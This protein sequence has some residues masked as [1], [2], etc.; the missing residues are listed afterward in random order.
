MN[1][2]KVQGQTLFQWQKD[3]FDLYFQHPKNS[4]FV[5]KSGR[6]R[7][8]THTLQ[9][10]IMYE[11]INK[12]KHHII[13]LT[14]TYSLCRKF[15]KDLTDLLLPIPKLIKNANSSVLEIELYNNAMITLKS[16]ESKNNLRGLNCHTLLIDEGAFINLDTALEC[17][18]FVNVSQGNIIIASTPLT[19]DEENNLFAK[20]WFMAQRGEKNVYSIDFCSY[21]TSALLTP[22]RKEMYRKQLP[23]NI[24]QNEIEGNFLEL[25]NNLWNIQPILRNDVPKTDWFVGGI[26]WATNEKQDETSFSIFN[27]DKQMYQLY[28][29]NDKSPTE[30]IDFIVNIL[31][32]FPIKKLVIEKNSIGSIYLDLLK[33][34]VSQNNIRTN[35]IPF[36]TTNES[37][38]KII[39]SMQLEI[40]NQTTSFL[41]D[42]ELILQ[43]SS[44]EMQTTKSGLI[45]YN[46][47]N[48]YHDDII[49]SNA[50]ALSA[51]SQGSYNIR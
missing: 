11:C 19:K 37:K 32:Q 50:L 42:N 8:K 17:F 6:Q 18:N 46:G 3:F 35:I 39:E 47:A 4:I 20:Y 30:T 45:T 2:N 43:Y 10:L 31:K 16:A 40:M 25:S 1:K 5:I 23:Y 51:F 9:N 15:F 44:Y 38:R 34:K 29:F 21:D 13:V 48:G 28:H 49:M 36:I 22:E 27:S 14:P 33:K 7:A 26:D 41:S 12:P 24:F